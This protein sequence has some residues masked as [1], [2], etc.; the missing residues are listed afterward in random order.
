MEW[1][2]PSPMIETAG[3]ENGLDTPAACAFNITTCFSGVVPPPAQLVPISL[4]EM[5]NET[6]AVEVP[7]TPAADAV[8]FHPIGTS[9]E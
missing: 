7:A 8:S 9:V 6:T 1:A 3:M 5:L 4:I 2:R